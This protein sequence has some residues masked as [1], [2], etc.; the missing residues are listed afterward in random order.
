MTRNCGGWWRVN[1]VRWMQRYFFLCSCCNWWVE[2]ERSFSMREPATSMPPI[3]KRL[4]PI[5]P[6]R[7]IEL[8]ARSTSVMSKQKSWITS[9]NTSSPS[10]NYSPINPI[11]KIPSFKAKIY[12]HSAS[13]SKLTAPKSSPHICPFSTNRRNW[14]LPLSA[15]T[16]Y[17]ASPSQNN[18]R[19]KICRIGEFGGTQLRCHHQGGDKGQGLTHYWLRGFIDFHQL[20]SAITLCGQLPQLHHIYRQLRTH[21][22]HR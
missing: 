14:R 17:P 11:P 1:T 18:V 7:V 10:S 3:R 15:I 5:S 21:S 9:R 4:A 6:H 19:I 16:S 20:S 2:K 22:F 12:N 8:H 13:S